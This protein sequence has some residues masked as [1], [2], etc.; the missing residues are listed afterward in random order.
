MNIN[1][2]FVGSS[3]SNQNVID[4]FRGEWSSKMPLEAEAIA[5]PGH[6]ALFSDPR[7]TWAH[8]LI[9]PFTGQTVLELGP[10]EGAHSYM[11]ERYGAAAITSVEANS[12]AFLKCLCIKE[13]MGLKNVSYKL[14]SFVPFL[15]SCGSYDVIMASGVLYHMTDPIE[16]LSLLMQRSDSLIMWTH[17]FDAKQ[18]GRLA[19]NAYF[20]TPETLPGTSYV[21]SK[22]IYPETSLDWKGF[23]GG[24]EPYAIW[25]ERDSILRCFDDGGFDVQVNFEQI[26]HPSGPAFAL[27]A[28]RRKTSKRT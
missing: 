12:R 21:G 18:T 5:T 16:L 4:L 27:C 20:K 10:L 2:V 13:I 23:S 6:A 7:L 24:I 19:E 11:F 9:G 14:G 22:R 8:D 17:Y 15:K 28:T 25:L 3:P 26:D 1:S